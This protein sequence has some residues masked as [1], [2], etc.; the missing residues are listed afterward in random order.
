MLEIAVMIEG[1]MGLN[2][3][4]WQAIAKT[5]EDVGFAGLYRSD[6]FTNPSPPDS[7]SL[8]L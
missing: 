7:D 4:R 5:V 2:W 3:P 1:Q 8:E 6:H